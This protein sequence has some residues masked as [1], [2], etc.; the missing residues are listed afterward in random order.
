MTSVR[1]A[2]YMSMSD[3]ATREL[4]DALKRVEDLIHDTAE[5]GKPT[6][7]SFKRQDARRGESSCE[8][9]SRQEVK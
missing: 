6:R 1:E 2:T 5:G 4:T 8:R 9:S 7:P 3:T